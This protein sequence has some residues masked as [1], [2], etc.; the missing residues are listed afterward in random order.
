MLTDDSQFPFGK[1][2]GKPLSDI[3]VEYLHWFWHNGTCFNQDANDVKSYIQ[4]NMDALKEE[5][6]D[7]IWKR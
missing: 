3:P 2:K 4:E 6:D 5:N 7:L 1:H